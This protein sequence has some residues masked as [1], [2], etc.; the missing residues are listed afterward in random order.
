MESII[1]GAVVERGPV[2][3]LRVTGALTLKAPD[4]ELLIVIWALVTQIHKL[5]L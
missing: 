5:H 3:V 1:H 2:K 4:Q